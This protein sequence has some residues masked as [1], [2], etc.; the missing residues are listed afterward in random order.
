M[1]SCLLTFINVG[2][3][4]KRLYSATQVDFIHCRRLYF[5]VLIGIGSI[6]LYGSNKLRFHFERLI[7]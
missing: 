7:H 4:K 6:G 5:L 1:N 3:K 2:G